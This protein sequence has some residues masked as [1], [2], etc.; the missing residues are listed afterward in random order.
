MYIARMLYPVEV[1]GPGQRVG[2]W[3]SGCNKR[4]RNCISPDLLEQKEDQKVSPETVL[5]MIRK[6]QESGK[7]DGFTISGGE[8]FL[9][10]NELY[11]LLAEIRK[12]SNDILVYTGYT[13]DELGSKSHE[14]VQE[15]FT[16]I[17]V[18]V[19]G[20]Y[21]DERNT[22]AVLRGSDNQQ[23]HIFNEQLKDRYNEYCSKRQNK[24]QS[25]VSGDSVIT[26]GI[27]K[28]IE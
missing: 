7:I 8:P 26:V 4:C 16:M 17:G 22:D 3:T 10:I 20:E 1:L 27:R 9:Q 11:E 12:I 2:I 13:L 23:I 28:R 15:C 18:L 5:A 21:I 25:F 19:D 14:S 6:I 24:L